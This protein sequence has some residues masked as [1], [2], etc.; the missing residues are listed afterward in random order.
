M[1]PVPAELVPAADTAE[2]AGRTVVYVG[3][4][5][6]ARGALVVADTIKP[7]SAEAVRRFRASAYGRYCSPMTTP[8]PPGRSPPR[9]ASTR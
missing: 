9:W 8:A 3:W 4:D 6:R 5:G 2:A 7:T 1:S